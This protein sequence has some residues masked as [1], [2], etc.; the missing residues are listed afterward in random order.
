ML[1]PLGFKKK[2]LFVS[3]ALCLAGS[4]FAQDK[5]FDDR[6]YLV[7]SVGVFNPDR[8]LESEDVVPGYGL[9]VGKPVS[10]Y[11]DVQMGLNY[12]ISDEDSNNWQKGDYQFWNAGA[13]VLFFAMRGKLQPFGVI[14]FG[15]S[16][17]DF[18][19][20]GGPA[21]DVHDHY[22]TWSANA[23][24]GVQYD[25]S[26]NFGMQADARHYFTR[27][28]VENLKASDSGNNAFNLGFI[29]RIGQK[30]K[31]VVAQAPEPVPAPAPEPEPQAPVFEPI[32]LQAETLF[33]F[34]KAVLK[35]E[36]KSTL[37]D[38]ISKM[39]EFPEIEVILVTGHA[40]RIGNDQYNM[41]LSQRRADAVKKYLVAQGVASDRIKTVAKGENEPVAECKGL[42]GKKLINCLAPNRRVVVEIQT[43][44]E[45]NP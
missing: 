27:A 31:P 16:R 22:S 24:L 44:R 39:K 1:R 32:T 15:W 45:V 33:D 37:S 30:H 18:D 41:R 5:M 7:P 8:D 12:A 34:D 23:G 40:D 28:N 17:N 21:P 36:G 43:Q 14:G 2:G 4:A 3:A 29:W 9:H 26:D 25:F 6:W 10:K 13:D 42:S 11:V 19:Y 20:R 38:L 35:E